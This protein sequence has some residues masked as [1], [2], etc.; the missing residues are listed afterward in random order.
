MLFP[1]EVN[2]HQIIRPF[3]I[4]AFKFVKNRIYMLSYSFSALLSDSKS[5]LWG[6]ETS[7]SLSFPDGKLLLDI[8]QVECKQL[9][10]IRKCLSMITF[11]CLSLIR[12]L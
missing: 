5:L 10:Y 11:N 9:V 7:S 12:S 1:Q 8:I 4:D 6:T 2:V 3:F